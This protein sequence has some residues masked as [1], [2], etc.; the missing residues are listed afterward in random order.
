MDIRF[1]R[2]ESSKELGIEAQCYYIVMLK[3][4]GKLYKLLPYTIWYCDDT[5][6]Y[7]AV[8]IK[9]Y[10]YRNPHLHDVLDCGNHEEWSE[11]FNTLKDA[12]EYIFNEV[13]SGST[14][15]GCIVNGKCVEGRSEA[16]KRIEG[17]N[18]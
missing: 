10:Q 7:V 5:R 12:K 18:S 15:N 9:T 4:I 3:E 17:A 8:K 2:E 11:A 1:Y 6:C 14:I 16:F 13:K